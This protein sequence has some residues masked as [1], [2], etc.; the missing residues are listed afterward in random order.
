MDTLF[1]DYNIIG[2]QKVKKEFSTYYN[3]SNTISKLPDENVMGN[4]YVKV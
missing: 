4:K 1:Y 2:T 3:Q